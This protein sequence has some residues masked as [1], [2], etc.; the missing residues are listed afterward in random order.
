MLTH[1]DIDDQTLTQVMRLGNFASK[2]LAI[3]TALAEYERM[4][5]R[6]SILALR[7]KVHW[8]GDLRALR[9]PRAHGLQ[10]T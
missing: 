2:K 7:G 6:K 4:L 10:A 1:I 9:G 3:N 5:A 8:E